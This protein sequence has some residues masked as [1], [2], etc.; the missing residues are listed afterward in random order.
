LAKLDFDTESECF[1]PIIPFD[2]GSEGPIDAGTNLDATFAVFLDTKAVNNLRLG[3]AMWSP[4][5]HLSPIAELLVKQ[6]VLPV[7]VADLQHLRLD[8]L[9]LTLPVTISGQV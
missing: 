2:E 5:T 1:R 9:D 3:V 7:T 8:S 6:Q 4:W